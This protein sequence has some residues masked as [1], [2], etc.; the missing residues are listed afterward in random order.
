[1]DWKK[2]SSKQIATMVNFSIIYSSLM[3][4]SLSVGTDVAI[5]DG[6]LIGKI[7]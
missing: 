7:F 6:R 1:M 4:E 3:C 2:Y 5:L